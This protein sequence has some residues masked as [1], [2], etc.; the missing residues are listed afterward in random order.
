MKSVTIKDRDG[1]ILIKIRKLKDGSYEK[2][3]ESSV[4]GVIVEVKTDDNQKVVWLN[5]RMA[6][7]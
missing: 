6:K 3:L 5:E 7:A 1:N 2:V 4:Q